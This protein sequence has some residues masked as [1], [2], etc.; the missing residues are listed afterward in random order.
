MLQKV[1]KTGVRVS[2]GST[3]AA[4]AGRETRRGAESDKESDGDEVLNMVMHEQQSCRRDLPFLR[5]RRTR[6][7][8]FERRC[9]RHLPFMEVADAICLSV[10]RTPFAICGR[11]L[12]ILRGGGRHLPFMEGGWT[13]YAIYGGRGRHLPFWDAIC[14]FRGRLDAICHLSLSNLIRWTY[15]SGW[16]SGMPIR[17]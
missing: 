13:P 12:P 5:G 17:I 15:S 9:G 10:L 11:H 7:A 3:L 6:Y 4:E 1:R 16:G 14:L 8:I 2:A